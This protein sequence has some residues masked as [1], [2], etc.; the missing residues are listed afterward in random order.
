[1]GWDT[2]KDEFVRVSDKIACPVCNHHDGCLIHRSGAYVICYHVPS[3]TMWR[4]GFKHTI[5]NKNIPI[6]AEQ[7]AGLGSTNCDDYEPLPS[8]M[9]ANVVYRAAI[10]QVQLQALA[11]T[12]GVSTCSVDALCVGWSRTHE[13]FTCPM[14]DN[15]WSIQ[16]IQLR[17]LSG[18]KKVRY[19]SKVG[20]FLPQSFRSTSG[21]TFVCEGMSD[22]A[23]ALTLGLNAVGRFNAGCGEEY[24]LPLLTGHKVFIIADNGAVGT[25]GA[26]ELRRTLEKTALSANV[27]FI[28]SGILPARDLR[29]FLR[30]I[31]RYRTL[32]YILSEVKTYA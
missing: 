22:T 25:R 13:A 5:D 27:I 28:P 2:I 24:L 23:A 15:T 14:Y 16:G 8:F 17:T 10:T 30:I 20:L 31:G 11:D 7:V 21:V 6:L 4:I 3:D 26:V 1:M 12:L 32:Q 29:E 9:S 18:A 19:K